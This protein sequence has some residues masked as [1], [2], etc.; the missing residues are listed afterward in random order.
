MTLLLQY[1]LVLS[2]DSLTLF[3]ELLLLVSWQYMEFLKWFED[4]CGLFYSEV[5][6]LHCSVPC[7]ASLFITSSSPSGSRTMTIQMDMQSI[8]LTGVFSMSMSSSTS[9]RLDRTNI[10]FIAQS[11]SLRYNSKDIQ[12]HSSH[13][14][15]TTVLHN[16]S[17][18]TRI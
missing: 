17:A 18:E 11:Q 4:V 5:G 9:D 6:L 13:Q 7:N 12:Q 14:W 15:T 10:S 16:L 1:R 3:V 8:E 2:G